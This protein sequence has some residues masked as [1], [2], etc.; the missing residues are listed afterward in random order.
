MNIQNILQK[1]QK[2]REITEQNNIQ[3]CHGRLDAVNQ[4]IET[5]RTIV[6][7]IGSVASGKCT[8]A[9]A[10]VGTELL[11]TSIF[12]SRALY[13]IKTGA[14][15][16]KLC[17]QN[18][19]S[20]LLTNLSDIGKYSKTDYDLTA[21]F[22]S[23]VGIF[24]YNIELRTGYD[25]DKASPVLDYLL[26]DV[27]LLCIKATALFSIDEKQLLDDFK[28]NGHRRVII[29][30]THLNN[31]KTSELGNVIDYVKTKHLDYPDY[32]VVY[33]SEEPI[34]S[35]PDEIH[36]LYGSEAI[37]K[38]LDNILKYGIDYAQRITIAN[39]ILGKTIDAC[40]EE[41]NGQKLK[42][43]E[44]KDKKHADFMAKVSKREFM[45]L[46]W[47]D[48]RTEYEKM[49]SKCID[50]ILSDL[51]KGKTKIYDRLQ[52]SIISCSNPRDWWEKVLPLSMKTEI[53]NLT[54]AIDNK[55]QAQLTR[56]FNWLNRE[57]QVRFHQASIANNGSVG[58]TNFD[59]SLN[60]S[61]KSFQNLQNARYFSM[62]GGA[63]LSTVLLCCGFPFFA[64]ISVACAIF[65]D[66]FIHKSIKNQ[67]ES[68]KIAVGNV[69]DDVITKISA[70]IP[71]R[72]NG[73]YEE[74]ARGIAEKEQAWD[75]SL[76]LN[77]FQCE[78]IA[79]IERVDAVI[80]N[81]T[82]LKK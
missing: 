41:L 75:E 61:E 23:N 46:G 15:S 18:G 20:I 69:L 35:I 52:A 14:E 31:V 70:M 39:A 81:L 71:S 17:S 5:Q 43:L 80:R 38:E 45:R 37:N 76:G 34:D 33:F 9:N 58:E 62:A 65:G 7:I 25:I 82:E 6:S 13:K 27:V 26:S 53:E 55:I 79:A 29:C 49:Q 32:P 67:Q 30:I 3:F 16:P 36:N 48:I 54:T 51:N 63:A 68:L 40:V 1:T 74:I 64:I 44:A 47:M 57:I 22:E 72:V 59:Y 28:K 21:C 73:L 19:Q 2:L 42:L 78:E 66:K 50:T 12:K 56:D 60:L 8:L 10:I 24:Q 77:E 4:Y 11:P